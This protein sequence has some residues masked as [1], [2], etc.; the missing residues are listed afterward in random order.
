MKGIDSFYKR[1]RQYNLTWCRLLLKHYHFLTRLCLCLIIFTK[2]QNQFM[3]LL[4]SPLNSSDIISCNHIAKYTQL[5]QKWITSL[6]SEVEIL[7]Q[8]HFAQFN[9]IKFHLQQIVNVI[10]SQVRY[11]DCVLGP[12]FS[13]LFLFCSK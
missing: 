10:L 12:T 4:F 6:F 13:Q 1:R 8:R 11:L 3:L 9:R 2:W 5:N 7:I